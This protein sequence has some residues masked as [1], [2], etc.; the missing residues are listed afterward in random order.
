MY[1]PFQEKIKFIT[2]DQFRINSAKRVFEDAIQ[3][4][5]IIISLRLVLWIKLFRKYDYAQM[6]C[7]YFSLSSVVSAFLMC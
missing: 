5:T 2:L 3:I 1:I 6:V 4:N 7:V